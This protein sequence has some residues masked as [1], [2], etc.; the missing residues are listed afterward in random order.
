MK[1]E[2]GL[3][4]LLNQLIDT[5]NKTQEEKEASRGN[6]KLPNTKETWERIGAK[7]SFAELGLEGSELDDF[8][9]DWIAENGYTNIN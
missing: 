2:N 3:E 8:L 4:N 6:A 1:K 7:D 9:K 5:E